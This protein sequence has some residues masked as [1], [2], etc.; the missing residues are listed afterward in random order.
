[1]IARYV[2]AFFALTFIAIGAQSQEALLQREP[3]VGMPTGNQP[4]F[5]PSSTVH[6][7]PSGLDNGTGN[8]GGDSWQSFQG[9]D[10]RGIIGEVYSTTPI[11]IE[12]PASL[13][14][15]R[16]YDFSLVLPQRESRERKYERFRQA[17]E[18]YF[19][20]SAA[21]QSRVMDVYVVTAPGGRK[22]PAASQQPEGGGFG[23]FS[24]EV[25]LPARTDDGSNDGSDLERLPKKVSLSALWNIS[26]E[27]SLEAFCNALES[28]LDRPVL[29]ETSLRGEF[30]FH[31]A[32]N[33]TEKSNFLARLR[34]DLGLAIEPAKRNVELLVFSP[35]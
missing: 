19:H 11:R 29:N 17:V 22:P 14:V 5:P 10:L 18:N 15:G 1:M 27:G 20:I 34:N 23:G 26:G 9:Y 35:R 12:L 8:F 6:I 24:I 28:F 31:V 3:R 16:R 32:A 2:G 33:P 21:R 7:L 25:G 13:D 4:D 30:E